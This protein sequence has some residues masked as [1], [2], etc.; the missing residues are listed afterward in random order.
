[1]LVFTGK[2]AVTMNRLLI[3]ILT[4]SLVAGCSLVAP[5]LQWPENAYPR[6]YFEAAY[7]ED[8]LVQTYQTQDDYLLWVTRF[9]T[10]YSIAP[11]WQSLTEQVLERLEEP[12]RSVVAERLYHLGGRIGSEWAKDNA[13]RLLNTRNASVWRDAL[14][15]SLDQGELDD[16]ITRVE[17]D[18]ES[19]FAGELD[20]EDIYFERYYVDEFDF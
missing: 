4:L 6:D 18:V 1:M 14:I 11:G 16:Y 20:K 8:H 13:V 15:E 9:Y 19:I 5:E 7:E 12:H 10:G 17:E 3:T 2:P